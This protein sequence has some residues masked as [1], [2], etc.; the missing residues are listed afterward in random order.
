MRFIRISPLHNELRTGTPVNNQADHNNLATHLTASQRGHLNSVLRQRKMDQCVKP[1]E[2]IFPES[3]IHCFP[4]FCITVD[5]TLTLM[6]V[7][8]SDR[9]GPNL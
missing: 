3:L 1:T 9:C 2:A 5:S 8:V 6:I 7:P 4:T